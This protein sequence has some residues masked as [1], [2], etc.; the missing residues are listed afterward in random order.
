[1]SIVLADIPNFP[2]FGNLLIRNIV[3]TLLAEKFNLKIISYAHKE[4]CDKLGIILFSGNIKYN[5]TI[6]LND[7]NFLI[8][9]NKNNINCNINPNTDFFQTN[10]ISKL[11]YNK[12]RGE[13][14]NNIIKNNK[15]NERYQNN[16]DIFIHLRL[17]DKID[18]NPGLDYYLQS[19]N[20]INDYNNI[21]I[22]SDSSDHNLIKELIKNKGAELI[23][24]DEIETIQFG[25]TCKYIILSHGTYSYFIGVLG[26]FSEIIY[27]DYK[28]APIWYGDV[29]SNLGWKI[30]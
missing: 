19:L 1:M 25:S 7:K 21:Y 8:I 16:K 30:I 9:Y 26:F 24:Y 10:E 11:I 18:S 13:N 5:K 17:G 22:S 20:E 6:I 23:L 15:F 29:F 14:K 27:P 4:K 3:T 2:R 12:L 28:R